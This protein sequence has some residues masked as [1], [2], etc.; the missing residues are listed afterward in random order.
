MCESRWL[1]IKSCHPYSEDSYLNGVWKQKSKTIKYGLK[2]DPVWFCRYY[3]TEQQVSVV[4]RNQGLQK[5]LTTN[6][7][8]CLHF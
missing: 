8:M 3:R 1:F 7:G 6:K 2:K 5:H 4:G